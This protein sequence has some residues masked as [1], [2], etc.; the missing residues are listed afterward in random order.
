MDAEKGKKKSVQNRLGEAGQEEN[1]TFNFTHKHV[2][3]Q[4]VVK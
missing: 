3:L 4:W 2:G 1:W